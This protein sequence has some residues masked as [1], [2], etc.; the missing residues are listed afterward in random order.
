MD[1]TQP[2]KD[3]LQKNDLKNNQH[4]TRLWQSKINVN[5]TFKKSHSS[6][7]FVPTFSVVFM[8]IS[9]RA[10]TRQKVRIRRPQAIRLPAVYKI[11]IKEDEWATPG[12]NWGPFIFKTNA[13]ATE[14]EPLS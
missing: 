4:R 3:Y 13:L 11:V 2:N 12:S 14:G 9:T 8:Y 10:F 1:I 6:E 5:T 7:L